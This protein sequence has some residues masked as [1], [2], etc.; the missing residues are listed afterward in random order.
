MLDLEAAVRRHDGEG[1][2]ACKLVGDILDQG[3]E[4]IDPASGRHLQRSEKRHTGPHGLDHDL[5]MRRRRRDIAGGG[6]H[7]AGKGGGLGRGSEAGF[8]AEDRLQ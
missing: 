6:E 1:P 7:A 8:A 4:E 5:C 3:A 2:V